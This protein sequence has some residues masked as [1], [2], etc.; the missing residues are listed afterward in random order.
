M[1][2]TWRKLMKTQT[3]KHFYAFCCGI[4]L[5]GVLIGA[6]QRSISLFLWALFWL[7]FCGTALLLLPDD[8]G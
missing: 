4:Q 6:L 8:S 3:A 2:M 7:G 5:M 1:M